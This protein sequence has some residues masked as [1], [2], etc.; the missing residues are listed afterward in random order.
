MLFT[1]LDHPF[2]E[3]EDLPIP[4]DE[5]PV[6]PADFVILAI[7]IVV[8]HLRA[9]DFIARE[10]HRNAAGKHKKRYE[11]FDL[12]FAQRL[13]RGAVGLAFD[14]T[15]PAEVIVDAVPIVFSI[16]LIVLG[17]IRNQIV[18]GETIVTRNE[19]DAVDR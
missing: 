18:H 3:S 12:T 6:H 5:I 16:T 15:I 11:N 4:I 14:A 17:V 10:D 19:V 9:P 7:R 2:P 1:E 8:A 13:N